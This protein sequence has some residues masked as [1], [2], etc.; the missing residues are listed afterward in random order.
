MRQRACTPT[1]RCCTP[2]EI[3][4]VDVANEASQ[5]TMEAA[6]GTK[7]EG[8]E[9]MPTSTPDPLEIGGVEAMRTGKG[10]PSRN[11]GT[12]ARKATGRASVGRS[13][14]IRIE[15]VP[16]PSPLPFHFVKFHVLHAPNVFLF[17]R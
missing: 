12:V 7:E 6:D 16:D 15:P 14:P 8:T 2:R 5:C 3:D 17:P 11:A 1:A 10:N 4:P 13:A 9:V